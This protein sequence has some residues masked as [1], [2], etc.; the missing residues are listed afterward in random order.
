MNEYKEMYLA[1]FRATE[2]AINTLIAAQQE[3]EERYL[4]MPEPNFKVFSLSPQQ[5]ENP[6]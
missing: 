4:S 2:Q 6:K 1:L 3:C 5:K